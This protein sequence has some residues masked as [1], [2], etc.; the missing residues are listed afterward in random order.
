[1]RRIPDLVEQYVLEWPLLED[2]LSLGIVNLSALAR[3]L[4]PRVEKALM[5]RV[6]DGAVMMALKRLTPEL[7]R[8]SARPRTRTARVSDLTVRSNLLEFTFRNSDTI[9]EKQKRLLH[10]IGRGQETFVTFTRGVFE[11]MLIVSESLEGAVQEI[12]ADVCAHR[13][14]LSPKAR[15]GNIE[16]PEVL[17]EIM[18]SAG[19]VRLIS[20]KGKVI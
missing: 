18:K 11:V 8:R 12:F 4:K 20:A 9:W 19:I 16:A 15:V 1:M 3:R 14:I 10:R 6:S 5:R 2:G 13:I 17:G 7:A